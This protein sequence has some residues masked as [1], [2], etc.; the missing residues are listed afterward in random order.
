MLNFL[1]TY[2]PSPVLFKLGSLPLYWYGL[3]YAVA[4]VFGYLLTHWL[5]KKQSQSINQEFQASSFKL[6]A[7][8]PDLTFALI[9][10]GLI[11]ARIYH[12]LNEPAYYFANPSQIFAVWNGGLAI[13]G[14]II[15]DAIFLWFY[16]RFYDLDYL[17]LLDLFAPALL[18]GQA[19]GR[20]GN[21]FNQELFG[22]PTSLPWGIPIDFINRPLGY[23]S[24]TYFHPTF[25]YESLWDIVGVV[26]LLYLVNKKFQAKNDSMPQH[27]FIFFL[28][29][30]YVSLG[31]FLV[32][33]MRVDNVPLIFGLRLPMLV[34]IVFM[35][36]GTV[37]LIALT[38]YKAKEYN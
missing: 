11:G 27:G 15:A 16:A 32:E 3:F 7:N 8:L 2:S 5:L 28:Y 22:R 20:W 10:I 23:E 17:R 21:Y 30:V 14:A 6:Q 36:I 29:L 9:V 19:I 24:F 18:L 25:L 37:G 38:R 34:S 4:I 12:V 33:L 31:R 35:L 26:I 1:H 13:H